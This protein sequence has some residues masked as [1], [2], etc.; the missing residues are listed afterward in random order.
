MPQVEIPR[1]LQSMEKRNESWGI[2][3]FENKKIEKATSNGTREAIEIGR[4]TDDFRDLEDKDVCFSAKESKCSRKIREDQ[5][6]E[7][8]LRDTVMFRVYTGFKS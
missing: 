4:K 1:Y 8:L 7:R 3:V 5:Q 2:I 6:F